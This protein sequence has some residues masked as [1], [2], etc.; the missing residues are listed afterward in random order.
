MPY[1][2]RSPHPSCL[3]A[4]HRLAS[5]RSRHGSDSHLGC[6]SLPC[7]RFATRWGRLTRQVR[8][9]HGPSICEANMAA[10]SLQTKR[11]RT[12][13]KYFCACFL[14][15]I[16]SFSK[17]LRNH[18]CMFSFAYITVCTNFKKP[19]AHV[20]FCVYYRFRKH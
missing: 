16:L 13:Q 1:K 10:R 15:R 9:W 19:F 8:T 2:R 4:I 14:L 12:W 3:T 17:T 6:H 11:E 20:F 7:R 5:A 18:S